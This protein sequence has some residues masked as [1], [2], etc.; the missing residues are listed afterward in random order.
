MGLSLLSA[1]QIQGN[2]TLVD[3]YQDRES[4]KYGYAITHNKDKYFRLIFS[5]NPVYDFREDASTA[6]T[7][8][9]KLVKEL[10]LSYQ[11]KCLVEIIGGEE[12][13]K[14]IDSIVRA[15]KSKR[16]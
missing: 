10:D 14:T 8:L 4:R 16:E 9:M 1:L 7:K 11:R 12:T 2:E 5:C 15:S 3:T 13:A 6:G